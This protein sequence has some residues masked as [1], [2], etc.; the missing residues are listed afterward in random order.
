MAPTPRRPAPGPLTA[1]PANPRY[2]TVAGTDGPAVYLTGS[3]IWNNLHD[4]LGPGRSCVDPPERNDFPA[5]L[6]FLTAHAH[7]FIRLWRWENFRS[8]AAGGGFH[9][10]MTPQPWPRTGLGHAVD[11]KP[12]FDLTRADEAFYSRL[13]ERV[14]A[15]GAAGIYVAVMLFEGWGLHLSEGADRVEGHPF[16]AANNVNDIGIASIVEYQVIEFVRRYEHEMGYDRHPIG[17]TMQYP[18]PDQ[19]KVNDPLF[20]GPADWVSPGFDDAIPPGQ[21]PSPPPPD[22]RW[23]VDPPANDGTKVVIAD[24]DH[25]A[26]GGGDALWAWKSFVRG[27]HPIL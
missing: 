16:H 8:Q 17:M 13:R 10:C 2:F 23:H 25:F 27:H 19:S 5:Y 6:D 24:T 9:L 15:A 21:P 4:G 20:T 1:S 3:H 12:K 14:A 22:T 18:V 26:P 11:G 7:N